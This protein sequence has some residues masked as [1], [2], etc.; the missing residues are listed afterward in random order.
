MLAV[1]RHL[2]TEMTFYLKEAGH[3]HMNN[4]HALYNP[5]ASLSAVFCKDGPK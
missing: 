2:N 5:M 4:G 1:V 3:K